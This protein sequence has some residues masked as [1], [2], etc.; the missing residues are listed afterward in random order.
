MDVLAVEDPSDPEMPEPREAPPRL[1]I[2]DRR[3]ERRR[4]ATSHLFFACPIE[5]SRSPEA[6]RVSAI[7][8]LTGYLTAGVLGGRENTSGYTGSR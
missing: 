1:E 6:V 3:R 5:I 7:P 2:G 8:M 4:P